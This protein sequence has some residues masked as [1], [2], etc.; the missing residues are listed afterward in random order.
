M[1]LK[2]Y[3]I[4]YRPYQNSIYERMQV[5]RSAAD[6]HLFLGEPFNGIQ[7]GHVFNN[8]EYQI[9]TRV[10]GLLHGMRRCYYPDGRLQSVDCWSGECS[11]GYYIKYDNDGEFIIFGIYESDFMVKQICI[12]DRKSPFEYYSYIKGD[13]QYP[14][15]DFDAEVESNK[16][17]YL[18]QYIP[19]QLEK[20]E[21][22]RESMKKNGIFNN[23]NDL[24]PYYNQQVA[25]SKQV[26]K[27]DVLPDTIKYIAGVD[28]AYNELELRMVGGIVILDAHT[29]EIV[30]EVVHEMEVTFPYIPGLFSFREIPPLREAFKKLKHKPDLIVCDAQGIAHPM[31]VGMATHLGIELD[32]PTIGCAKTRLVGSYDKTEM[33]K[34]RGDKQPMIWDEEIVGMALRTQDNVNPLFVSIGHKISIDTACSWI[35]RLSQKYRQPETT[36]AADQL[37]NKYMTER[38]IIDF[39]GDELEKNI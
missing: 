18:K 32:I 36:R 37:V 23:D 30:E 35:L 22:S 8:G 9:E 11:N 7:E 21:E 16:R 19:S 6:Q 27:E 26:I 13:K 1:N 12:S 39:M 29:L 10:N 17:N 38:T 33:G 24:S 4:K 34:N 14:Y 15:F 25:Y 5:R 28:V 31:G 20:W 2:E 3:I